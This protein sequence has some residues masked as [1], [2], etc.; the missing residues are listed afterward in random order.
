MDV[1]NRMN[2]VICSNERCKAPAHINEIKFEFNLKHFKHET[3]L[4]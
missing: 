1:Q 3:T 4:Y 2:S